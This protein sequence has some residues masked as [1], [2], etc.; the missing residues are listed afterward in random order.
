MV[1]TILVSI[2]TFGIIGLAVLF[3]VFTLRTL[4]KVSKLY[5]D[6]IDLLQQ[7]VHTLHNRNMAKSWPDF[8]NAQQ[9]TPSPVD[10][11]VGVRR[12]LQESGGEINEDDPSPDFMDELYQD[13]TLSVKEGSLEDSGIDIDNLTG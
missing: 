4:G 8:A 5:Q 2:L 6:Q 11:M 12:N 10:K 1:N 13:D 3:T 9:A 7:Q